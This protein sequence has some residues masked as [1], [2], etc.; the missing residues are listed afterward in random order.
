MKKYI[1]PLLMILFLTSCSDDIETNN[2]G[3]QAETDLGFFHTLEPTAYTNEDGSIT[4]MGERGNEKLKLTLTSISAGE[5]YEL[6][7]ESSN[8]ATFMTAEEVLYSTDSLGEG[9]VKIKTAENG[10]LYGSFNFDARVN[11][12]TG[13]TLNF[14]QGAFFGVPM[15]DGSLDDEDGEVT[16]P[17]D[18]DP[19]CLEALNELME[20]FDAYYE[21]IENEEENWDELVE[22]CNNYKDAYYN[23]IEVC[24]ADD[25]LD[26]EMIQDMEDLDCDMEED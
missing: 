11:G 6:G 4:I 13:D 26:D 7:G 23:L 8:V 10:E 1:L 5:E 17:E 14:S 16:L 19:D 21:A 3:L 20:A 12:H 15:I 22:A 24:G 25:L 9:K 2:P 18:L